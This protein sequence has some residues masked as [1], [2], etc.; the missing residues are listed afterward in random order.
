MVNKIISRGKMV[1][2]PAS[3]V[4]RIPARGLRFSLRFS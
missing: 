4:A 3:Y 2:T 1:Y